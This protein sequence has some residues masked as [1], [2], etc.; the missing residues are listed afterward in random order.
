LL[1]IINPI[2]SAR[3]A[4]IW[5]QSVPVPL[6]PQTELHNEVH[7]KKGHSNGWQQYK[8]THTHTHA[9]FCLKLTVHKTVKS[10]SWKRG[11]G[12]ENSAKYMRVFEVE[13]FFKDPL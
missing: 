1:L 7:W 2:Y 3:P 11:G 10:S 6:G 8:K 5:A 9:H 4:S 13:I 12:G